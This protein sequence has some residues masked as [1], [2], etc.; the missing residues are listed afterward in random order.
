[1][2]QNIES[3]F[4]CKRCRADDAKRCRC[5]LPL[6]PTDHDWD[7]DAVYNLW[8]DAVKVPAAAAAWDGG[9]MARLQL[10]ARSQA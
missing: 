6:V 5:S 9:S 2:S 1:M 4:F 10:P 7:A 8:P 3:S